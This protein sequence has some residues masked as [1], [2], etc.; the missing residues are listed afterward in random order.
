MN[1]KRISLGMIVLGALVGLCL[2]VFVIWQV[3][4]WEDSAPA[5]ADRG[6]EVRCEGELRLREVATEAIGRLVPVQP[7]TSETFSTGG[8]IDRRQLSALE[9]QLD[10]AEREI[11]RY[12]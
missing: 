3:A 7:S 9:N 11:N 12:C 4:P 10:Q 1:L 5:V 8:G 6:D 2:I